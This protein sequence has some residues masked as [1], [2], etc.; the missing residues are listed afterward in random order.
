MAQTEVD[1]VVV[2]IQWSPRKTRN[3][4]K[5]HEAWRRFAALGFRSPF[6]LETAVDL[7]RRQPREQSRSPKLPFLS[8]PALAQH[9]GQQPRAEMETGHPLQVGEYRLDR[10]Q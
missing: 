10:G 5:E 2:T 7:S 6:S 1:A 4:R 9:V 3:T 8:F